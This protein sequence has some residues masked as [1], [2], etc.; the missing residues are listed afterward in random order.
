MDNILKQ[1]AA[2]AE[3]IRSS[4]EQVA[5]VFKE[6]TKETKT[7]IE[8]IRETI[9]KT[10][11]YWNDKVS[12]LKSSVKETGTVIDDQIHKVINTNI[13]SAADAQ[14]AL[15]NE[16]DPEK[17][18]LLQN[19]VRNA[20]KVVGLM[21]DFT[22]A[23]LDETKK[24]R[25][26]APSV[27]G[28][29]GSYVING[30]DDEESL[31][32]LSAINVLNNQNKYL[33]DSKVNLSFDEKTEQL[34][35]SISGKREDGK[36]FSVKLNA[37]DY[38]KAD[39]VNSGLISQVPDF[40]EQDKR[41]KDYSIVGGK[42]AGSGGIKPGFLIEG[43]DTVPIRG[44]KYELLGAKEVNVKSLASQ[45]KK[46]VFIGAA[47]GVLARNNRNYLK[48]TYE[49]NLQGYTPDG[50]SWNQ[51]NNI[52]NPLAQRDILAE[53][54]TKKFMFDEDTG[55]VSAFETSGE[56]EDKK[57]YNPS[58]EI[59]EIETT[60]KFTPLSTAEKNA[61]KK[62]GQIKEQSTIFVDE[63]SKAISSETIDESYFLN[64]KVNGKNVDVVD[65][66]DNI[67]K[68]YKEVV[69]GDELK[70]QLIARYD[71]T[72]KKQL[73]S[74]LDDIAVGKLGNDDFSRK[75]RFSIEKMLGEKDI[76]PY[77]RTAD[78][79]GQQPYELVNSN[80]GAYDNLN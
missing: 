40:S 1:D 31:D 56:G 13:Q 8:L 48:N 64:K 45:V 34:M 14:I 9:N 15:V 39:D 75:I 11:V 33:K 43:R 41:A 42:G 19:R 25:E 17:R 7:K 12:N 55:L 79:T 35:L 18:R 68:L 22:G 30:K 70:D 57:Y 63:F 67:I 20:E 21:G 32:Y 53:A 29:E 5:N 46:E 6:K 44:G 78:N 60:P 58:G 23:L 74:L 80:T 51:F 26:Q 36:D 76:K 4:F 62:E 3:R 54:M 71:L 77:T 50:M 2:T 72:K 47:E 66:D 69:A 49:I 37:E 61:L 52:A 10:E 28:Q 16:T 73:Q 24:I 38:M 27:Y 59:R 65:I